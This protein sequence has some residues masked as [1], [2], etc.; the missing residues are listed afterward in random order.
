MRNVRFIA[1]AASFLV[2][3]LASQQAFAQ[4]IRTYGADAEAQY[5]T[6]QDTS[7]VKTASGQTGGTKVTKVT[8][9]DQKAAADGKE[10]TAEDGTPDDTSYVTVF[11]PGGANAPL[12]V[13]LTPD[14][15]YRG[16][17][18][19]TRD[20]VSHLIKAREK[21]ADRSN[22]NAVTWV[23]F[24]AND[25]STRV[26]FQTGRESNYDLG[27]ADGAVTV[28]FND[29]RLSARNFGR[30][31]DTSF[32][33]R[34]VTRIEVKQVDKSTVVA[35]IS[36]RRSEQ[37]DVDRSGNYLY[38]DFSSATTKPDAQESSDTSD[39]SAAEGSEE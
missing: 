5:G 31:I 30:F 22:R 16:V 17:I 2:V 35:T 8:A 18:P 26:F 37:P 33:N 9:G 12:P 28:T 29:T 23:G 38:L 10:G 1:F 27:Q 34:N 32:F 4:K 6:N 3:V 11:Q 20:E 14:K 24:Q 19:G 13:D 25:K 7:A 15:M 36:L 39:S 21:A